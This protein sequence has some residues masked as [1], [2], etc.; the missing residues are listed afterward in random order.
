MDAAS[1]GWFCPSDNIHLPAP[2]KFIGILYK[3]IVSAHKTS[4]D[5]K[6]G[7]ALNYFLAGCDN[8]PFTLKLFHLWD[9]ARLVVF[10]CAC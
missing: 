5:F 4:F 8:F 9:G 3:Y 10:W 6:R 2:L 1:L 7:D